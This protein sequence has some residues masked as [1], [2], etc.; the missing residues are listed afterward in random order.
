[1]LPE[2]VTTKTQFYYNT[3][4]VYSEHFFWT[5]AIFEVS[6]SD[7]IIPKIEVTSQNLRKIGARKDEVFLFYVLSFVN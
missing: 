5:S 1:M 2:T 4:L 6:K 7:W 3:L